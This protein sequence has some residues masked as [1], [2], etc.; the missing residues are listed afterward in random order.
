MIVHANKTVLQRT[1]EKLIA[2]QAQKR[3]K[4]S[5]KGY[6]QAKMLTVDEKVAMRKEKQDKQKALTKKKERY[7]VL[8]GKMKFAKAVWKEFRM[9]KDVFE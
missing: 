1:N 7:H 9:E 2:K 4:A 5:R 6:G 8:N 3:Q